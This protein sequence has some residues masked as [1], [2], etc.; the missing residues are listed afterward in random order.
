[1]L[2]K[3]FQ[4]KAILEKV[5]RDFQA[6]AV[7]MPKKDRF[8]FREK[9]ERLMLD[10]LED[11]YRYSYHPAARHETA[12]R[13]SLNVLIFRDFLRL[14]FD[15]NMGIPPGTYLQIGRDLLFVLKILKTLRNA[16]HF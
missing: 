7:R 4:L 1:M 8:Y 6:V 12:V 5:Y 3:D 14:A 13:M 11:V 16:A 10:T 15:S 2:S 9:T